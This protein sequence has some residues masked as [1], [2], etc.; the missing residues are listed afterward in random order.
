MLGRAA[1]NTRKGRVPDRLQCSIV[2]LALLQARNTFSMGALGVLDLLH[3]HL[4]AIQI[5]RRN[6]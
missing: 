6:A 1:Q 2:R 3:F 5:F 4:Q